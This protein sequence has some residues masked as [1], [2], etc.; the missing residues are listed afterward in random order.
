MRVWRTDA[1]LTKR[2]EE[3][4][5]QRFLLVE[6]NRRLVAVV[7]KY[8]RGKFE[9]T[10]AGTINWK[11]EV[12]RLN[13]HNNELCARLV[14][15]GHALAEIEKNL[16]EGYDPN[17]VAKFAHDRLSQIKDGAAIYFA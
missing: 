8:E 12:D 13:S 9:K 4:M 5:K 2:L 6:E 11:M 15:A 17:N 10:E 7:D 16:L 3:G 1:A 14:Y